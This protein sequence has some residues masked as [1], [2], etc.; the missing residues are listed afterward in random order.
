MSKNSFLDKIE[1]RT[2][3]SED[4]EKMRGS[5][6]ARFC[7]HCNSNVNNL[8]A[9]TRKEALRIVRESSGRICVRYVKNPDTNAPIFAD[10]LYQISRRTGIAA[11]VLG[12]SLSLS[13]AAYGQG[14]A[15]LPEI[16]GDAAVVENVADSGKIK[17][18]GATG[19][20]SGTISDSQ[21]AVISNINVTLTNKETAENIST[22]STG[23]GVYEFKNVASGIY[24]LKT[25]VNFGFKGHII[26][27]LKIGDTELK[28]NVQLDVSG[29]EVVV[30]MMAAVEYTNPLHIAV[31][32]DD[33]NEVKNLI[34]KG[35]K[36]NGKDENYNKITPLF[37]AVENGNAEIA[38][39][40]LAFG[41]KA[42]AKDANRQ[43]PLMRLDSDASPELVHLLIKYGAKI[44]LTDDQENTALI[45]AASYSNSEVL[46][47]LITGGANVNA[48]N[49]EGRT[50]LMNAAE[51]DNLENV[52]ALI[53]AGADVNLKNKEGETALDLTSDEEIEKLL[54]N[55]GAKVKDE[56]FEDN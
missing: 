36:I 41:A 33:L 23:E 18:E 21:G 38:E 5:D 49:K 15:K 56:K 55:Y 13:A 22:T 9:M 54:K 46:Q 3:C 39:T 26:E 6:K 7:S 28:V 35:A 47:A 14:E 27:G 42:N 30:G 25:E 4:W 44:N 32:N 20:I 51:E 52:R 50:A 43:T 24:T 40:L 17:I 37:I 8:S 45:L 34:S 31:S 1:V 2:P 53:L 29:E 48:Q 11:G 10:K 16:L 12:A 19:S